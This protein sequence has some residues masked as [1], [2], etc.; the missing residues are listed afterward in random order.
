MLTGLVWRISAL[1][2]VRGCE[3][4]WKFESAVGIAGWLAA[5]VQNIGR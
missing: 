3:L 1:F 4:S 5:N 2:E